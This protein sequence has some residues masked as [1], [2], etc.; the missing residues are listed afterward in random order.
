MKLTTQ[1]HLTLRLRNYT[2]RPPIHLYGV[3]SLYNTSILHSDEVRRQLN[4]CVRD[5]LV[6][7][8]KRMGFKGSKIG[9][10]QEGYRLPQDTVC[11]SHVDL[12]YRQLWVLWL[13]RLQ[14]WYILFTAL[15]AFNMNLV[16][17]VVT[18]IQKVLRS[19]LS[20][21]TCYPDCW[22]FSCLLSLSPSRQVQRYYLH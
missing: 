15:I 9:I 18:C 13:F 6:R 14:A 7:L 10:E 12:I 5:G 4:H 22:Y 17:V 3:H 11:M 2:L 20:W 16:G 1:L 19:S 21:D 8:I